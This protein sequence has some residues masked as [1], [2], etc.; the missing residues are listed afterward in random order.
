MLHFRLLRFQLSQKVAA[1]GWGI[2][3]GGDLAQKFN[4]R[5]NVEPFTNAQ[6]KP[7]NPAFGNTLLAAAINII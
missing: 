1:N 4:R 5:T 6:S 3:E 2:A 7:L